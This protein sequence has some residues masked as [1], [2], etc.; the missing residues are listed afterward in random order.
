MRKRLK[1][2]LLATTM[3]CAVPAPAKADPIITP[4]LASVIFSSGLVGSI[5][6]AIGVAS[7]VT[8]VLTAV[9]L[10]GVQ[11][12][13]GGL[14]AKDAERATVTSSLVSTGST[15]LT[16]R[17][18]LPA[19][20]EVRGRAI[21]GGAVNFQEVDP[22]FLT[23][24]LI[25]A[26]HPI[27]G[28]DYAQIL[29]NQVT[30]D[31]VTYEAQGS[32]YNTGATIYLKGHVRLGADSETV[33]P[34]LVGRYPS[35][36]ES[37]ATPGWGSA[38]L[39]ARYG[40]SQDQQKELFGSNFNV[41]W[42]VRGKPIFDPRRAATVYSENPALHIADLLQESWAGQV[43]SGQI[44]WQ[45][46]SRAADQCDQKLPTPDGEEPRY[47]LNGALQRDAN[48]PDVL[49]QM[50]TTCRGRL[51]LNGG[52]IG[53][54]VGVPEEPELTIPQ[55]IIAGGFEVVGGTPRADLVNRV[56]TRFVSLDREYEAVLGPVVQDDAAIAADGQVYEKKLD[57]PFTVSPWEAQRHA[58]AFLK[59]ARIGRTMRLPIDG[60]TVQAWT[61]EAGMVVR[62][63]FS[64]PILKRHDGVWI[65]EEI[66]LSDDLTVAAL[67]LSEYDPSIYAIPTY[68]PFEV[69][70]INVE[71]AS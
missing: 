52:K 3:L 60:N 29:D 67:R 4:T 22:P 63:S 39:E 44:D 32:P 36:L 66:E 59:D 14:F 55:S 48:W 18:A 28:I 42:F 21:V 9:A 10:T 64:S 30:F 6:T 37:F 33:S 43:P 7:A 15:K 50:L 8:G 56:Q 16:T 57:L 69:A 45:S 68:Q 62:T 54:R 49:A 70:S 41:L 38:V 53:L 25:L 61:V 24:G 19:Q 46:F 47:S 12:V 13:V 26:G 65:V 1:A 17:Q 31:P 11:Q 2:L 27:D 71:A 35:V 58:H 34:L 5:G 40:S 20:V 23:M 51:T